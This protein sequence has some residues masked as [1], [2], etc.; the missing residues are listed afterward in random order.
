MS[1]CD[2]SYDNPVR[3]GL[4]GA[5]PW[6]RAMHARTLAAGPETRLTAVWARRQE[7]A[8]EVAADHGAAAAATFD[9][10]LDRCEAVAFAVPPAVQAELAVRAAKA[11]KALLLEK[12]LG[13]DLASARRVTEAIEDAGVVSQLVLTKRYHPA[14]REFL[15]RAARLEVTGARSCYLHG[16][17]LGGDFATAWRLEHGALLDLGPHLLDLLDAAVGPIVSVRG[18]GDPR[19]WIELT[20]EHENGAVSQASLSGT[21]R[22]PK[23][24][25]RIELLGP[26]EEL[27]YDT[28]SLDHEECW[29]VLRA[30]FA[31]A[32]RAGA[33][34]P[35]DARRG[36][37]L[38]ELLDQAVAGG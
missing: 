2:T 16:A 22:L 9:E 4:V 23:A 18:T 7:A 28:G 30:E 32:V 29:P 24:R 26:E 34:G 38:Q 13:P 25:T 8:A 21:V 5:G 20:C 27:V 19:R 15:A 1:P 10:L 36:L 3:V 14:T 11:G 6:A 31:A 17:F 33:S 37:R 35:I 12:P